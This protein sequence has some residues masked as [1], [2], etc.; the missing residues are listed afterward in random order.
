MKL[1][2]FTDVMDQRQKIVYTLTRQLKPRVKFKN[3]DSFKRSSV[4]DV[5]DFK[6]LV[7]SINFSSILVHYQPGSLSTRAQK[8]GNRVGIISQSSVLK[9]DLHFIRMKLNIQVRFIF[10]LLYELQ[11]SDMTAYFHQTR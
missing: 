7:R 8:F 11:A 9:Y 3:R 10:L 5:Y 2:L 4:S 6:I 1:S